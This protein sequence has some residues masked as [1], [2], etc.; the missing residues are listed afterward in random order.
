[1][2]G[3]VIH[4]PASP[5]VLL[6]VRR[7]LAARARAIAADQAAL[8]RANAAALGQLQDGAS[9]GWAIQCGVRALRGLPFTVRRIPAP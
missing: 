6:S 5:R 4:L 2:P 8:A 9:T 3:T 7:A 1:M